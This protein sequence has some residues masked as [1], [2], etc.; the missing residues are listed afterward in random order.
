MSTCS[1]KLESMTLWG[2]IEIKISRIVEEIDNV[3][4]RGSRRGRNKP[5]GLSSRPPRY[6]R[7][8]DNRLG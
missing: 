7:L 1:G 6:Y 8:L 3:R 2:L 4:R 5:R